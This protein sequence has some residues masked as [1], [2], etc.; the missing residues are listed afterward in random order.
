MN[1]VMRLASACGT[2]L[3]TMGAGTPVPAQVPA[4][5]AAMPAPS[6]IG[7]GGNNDGYD[8]AP[9]T[10]LPV[11]E[12][13]VKQITSRLPPGPFQPT[14]ESLKLNYR[15]P[16]WFIGAKFGLFMHFGV[17]TVPAYG[18]EWYE[19]YVYS[20]RG[21]L[22]K[23]HIEHYGP[24]DKFGY[25]DFIPQFT[26][27]N[28]DPYAWARLFKKTGAR[29]VVPTA[30][31]HENFAMWDS[32]VT[33][34][35]AMQMGP[36][37]DIIGE[38][39]K[40]VRQQGMKFGVS[41]HGIENFQFINPPPEMIAQMKAE[42]AD[43]FDPKWE[44]FYNVADRSDAACQKFLANW[45]ARN[46][47]LIDKYQP[48]MLWFDNGVDQRYL[49]PL[50]LR[51]AA[52][53]YN[54]AKQWG[55]EVSISTKKAAYSPTD[56]NTQ[57]IGSILDFEIRNPPG[58]RTGEWQVDFPLNGTWGYTAG[59]TVKA[60]DRIIGTLADAVSKNGTFLLN[61]SPKSDGTIP[62]DQQDTLLAVG[63]WLEMNGE[64]IYDTHAWTTFGE[65]PARGQPG[66]NIRFTVKVDTLYAIVLGHMAGFGGG[67]QVSGPRAGSRRQGRHS[68]DARQRRQPGIH[69]GRRRAAR[70]A[71]G[72]APLPVRLRPEDHRTDDEPFDLHGVRGTRCPSS[73][74]SNAFYEN[75]AVTRLVIGSAGGPCLR[76]Y[77][78][79]PE[80][81][82]PRQD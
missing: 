64:A 38:L 65:T 60:P 36:K 34:Y 35:N 78:A 26:A 58:I 31:H 32:K 59:M 57:T 56:N 37:R 62:Q 28:F 8:M 3:V 46:V 45:Y 69:A 79:G 2:A 14:W 80:S 23:W 47:E 13:A 16:Q 11:V 6:P 77:R 50:K 19:K 20:T 21:P 67:H 1:K 82:P 53:Y 81:T 40:A 70:D 25:K 5:P 74:L 9:E 41:N 72:H 68:D 73:W 43:L 66:Q 27:K 30:E 33:P 39:S 61:I 52:Y 76:R 48:D 7:E 15:V 29:F 22:P 55:K 24:Q 54:R 71:A 49:D 10:T 63:K 12:G 44:D 17:Y 75:F 4:L 42:H 51:I 18:N